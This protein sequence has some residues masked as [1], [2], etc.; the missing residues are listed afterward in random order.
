MTQ[1]L[2]LPPK[3]SYRSR[4]HAMHLCALTLALT[5]AGCASVVPDSQLAALTQRHDMSLPAAQ[6]AGHG[7]PATQQ[8]SWWQDLQDPQLNVLVDM[9]QARNLNLQSAMATMR[10]ARALAGLAS[11]EGLP[12]GSLALSA[13]GARPSLAEVDPYRLGY[14]RPPHQNLIHISQALSWEIDLFGR[15]GTAQ[16]VAE[17]ELDISRADLQA[18]QALLQAD[19]VDRYI[20][21]RAAQQ[22]QALSQQQLGLN[23]A[24]RFQT[25]SR[26]TA[27]LMDARELNVLEAE[28]KNLQSEVIDAQAQAHRHL[29]VLAVLCGHSP[30]DIERAMPSLRTR[31]PLPAVPQQQTLTVP[32]DLLNRLPNVARADAALRASMGQT[33]LAQREHLPRLSL[34]ATIG[35]NETSSR[36]SKAGAVRYVAGPS[37]QWD[38]L[39]AGRRQAREAAAQAG[40]ERAWAHLEQTVLQA[41]ADGES[42]LR[43]WQAQS[44]AWRQAQDAQVAMEASA[45]Y[46]RT[47][48]ELGLEP[49]LHALRDK[50]QALIAQQRSAQTQAMALQSWVQVQLALGTWQP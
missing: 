27:G 25:Q 29:A 44:T 42:S 1:H 36:M 8:R 17:R 34:A 5:L 20:Q 18:A 9:A 33:V 38:W 16:A 32:E 10:E 6:A 46:T 13:Q 39:D 3:P 49:D 47:R 14:P 30:A 28:A 15:V 26:V 41:L 21:L 37:L 45:Q 22:S 4:P 11:R 19:V 7:A 50:H 43:T 40:S 31:Q 24:M 2:T 12:Q 23:E 35:L 48:A